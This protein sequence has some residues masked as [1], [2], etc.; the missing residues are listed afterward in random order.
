VRILTQPSSWRQNWPAIAVGLVALGLGLALR[1]TVPYHEMLKAHS[2]SE[3]LVTLGRYLAWPW[4]VLPP[5]AAFNLF[6]LL[7]LAWLYLRHRE[8]RGPAEEMV[9]GVSL[10]A[11]LQAVASA[12]ARGGQTYPQWR[13]MDLSCFLMIANVLSLVLLGSRHRERLPLKRYSRA[14]SLLWTL[15]CALGLGLLCWRAW[16]VDIP[17]RQMYHRLQLLTTRAYLATG[18]RQYLEVRRNEYLA[19]ATVAAATPSARAQ[20]LVDMLNATRIRSLLPACARDPLQVTPESAGCFTTNRLRFTRPDIPGE[21]AW[22]S[23][24]QEALARNR[25]FESLPV[26][27]SK[28][29]Y[30]EI[31]VAGDLPGPGMSLQLLDLTSG[32]ISD[33]KPRQAPGDHWHGCQVKAPAGQF[34]IVAQDNSD[35]GWFAFKPPREVGWVSFWATRALNA[36]HYLLFIGLGFFLLSL[37]ASWR[38]RLSSD[39]SAIRRSTS[40][41]TRTLP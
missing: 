35:P 11:L 18:D 7:M 16:T 33:I 19:R 8:A 30:L 27:G 12:Y 4:I 13:Y 32:R 3:F 5:Y 37:T 15:A 21:I 31:A 25:R 41:A 22:G 20:A 1:V 36:W 28:L 2:I 24:A 9:L 39:N 23:F 10:W 40:T 26:P 29:P 6:P 34:K 17:L 38:W 14:A